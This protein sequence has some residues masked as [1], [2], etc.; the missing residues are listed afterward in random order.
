LEKGF[1]D[2]IIANIDDDTPRLAY[3]DW[4]M[5]NGQ[6]DR[7]EFIRV[8]IERARRP[9]WDAAQVRLRLLERQ[10]LDQH[11]ERWLK[12]V[13]AIKGVRWEGFRRGIVAEVSFVSFEVMRTKAA[14]ARAAAPV[15]AVT[16][17]WPRE[18]EGR[19]GRPIAELR[20]LVLHGRPW[21]KEIDRLA[22]SP[23]LSTLRSLSVLGLAAEDLARLVASPHLSGLRVLRLPSNGLGNA[24]VRALTRAAT[25][26][27]LEELD[28]S[29]P[30]YYESYYDDPILNQAGMEAL[31]DWAG[32]AGLRRLT[33]EGH[34]VRR[35]G[36]GALLGSPNAAALKELSLRKGRLDGEAMGAFLTAVP[37]LR[38]EALDIGNNVLKKAGVEYLAAAPCLGELK[39]LRL[40]RCEVSL[41]GA[42]K[43]A[44]EAKFLGGLRRLEVGHNSFGP[45][46]LGALLEREPP[47]LH[48]LGLRD[49][50]LFDKGAQALAGSPA[51]DVLLEV[52]L[53]RNGLTHE[54]ARALGESAHLRGLVVLRL[55]DNPIGA[56]AAAGLAASPLGKRLGSLEFADPPRPDDDYYFD[57][58]DEEMPL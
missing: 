6:D 2:D 49:N 11:G 21:D 23:Q 4:L 15:E 46:G 45:A 58:E 35:A 3:A 52:D 36:L 34:D 39:A 20:E 31:A 27:A 40:D 5:E 13:Q 10:L 44:N 8:Q 51:S 55:T 33:L 43:L 1:L 47:A 18:G 29:G 50:D 48:T 26:T 24:G 37:G 16:T 57:E 53:A 12:E 32:L 42:K 56:A 7:S 54:A 19:G 28:L 25:L 17:H 14:A 41:D 38:L 22:D 9:A 30:G